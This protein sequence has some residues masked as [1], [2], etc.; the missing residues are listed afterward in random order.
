M[1]GRLAA[2]GRRKPMSTGVR[3]TSSERAELLKLAR[4]RAKVAK[5]D[6]A[7]RAAELKADFERQL[8]S[9]YHFDTDETWASAMRSAEE[10]VAAAQDDV[11]RRCGELGIPREL[12]PGID[13]SWYSRG[14]NASRE[15]RAE[16]RK[17]A[18]TRIDALEKDARRQI[19]ARSVEIQTELVAE[20]LTSERAT[21][22][23]H[24]LPSPAEL[25]PALDVAALQRTQLSRGAHH[26]S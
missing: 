4:A 1:T 12:A 24:A 22:F 10:A 8:A 13:V 19:E 26:A 7:S 6:A 14:Q 9:V 16:L 15:R 2:S 23:L 5:D 25:M 18:Y 11:A 21:A 3:M 17:V 20:G